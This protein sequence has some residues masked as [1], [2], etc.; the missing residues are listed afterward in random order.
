MVAI[1]CIVA[2]ALVF[3][4]AIAGVMIGGT[5]AG[6]WGGAA[7]LVLGVVVMLLTLWLLDKT[8]G[9]IPE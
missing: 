6:L 8:K 5:A 1:G 9:G 4:G 2:V 7:G 3:A